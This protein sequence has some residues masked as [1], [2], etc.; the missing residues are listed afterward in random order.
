MSVACF[1]A[2]WDALG[3]RQTRLRSFQNDQHCPHGINDA[4][5]QI[6]WDLTWIS[7]GLEHTDYL[8]GNLSK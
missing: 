6:G 5:R 8:T 3:G 7:C 1:G 4:A 2:R